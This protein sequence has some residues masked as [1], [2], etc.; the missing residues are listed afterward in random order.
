MNEIQLTDNQKLM[1]IEMKYYQGMKWSPKVGD[2][3]VIVRADK[4]VFR[5]EKIEDGQVYFSCNEYD[6]IGNFPLEGFADKDF[7]VNR[8]FVP[9]FILKLTEAK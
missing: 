3:Y 9:E 4:K 2:V 1:A 5:I 8:V 7:G 6:S